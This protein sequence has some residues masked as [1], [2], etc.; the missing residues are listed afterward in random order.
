MYGL[1]IVYDDIESSFSGGSKYSNLKEKRK[2]KAYC[3][4]YLYP[5]YF[6]LG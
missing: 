1:Y 3:F 4:L 5:S 6:F 2:Q